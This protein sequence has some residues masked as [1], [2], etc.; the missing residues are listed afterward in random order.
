MTR[1]QLNLFVPHSE[2]GEPEFAALRRHV[3]ATDTVRPQTP[4]LTLAHPRNP[5]ALGNALAAARSAAAL[6]LRCD[7]LQWIE[8]V[9]QQSW[10]VVAVYPLG[11]R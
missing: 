8:H 11:N 9:D 5:K 7:R 1:R 10:S 4:H 3:L 6:T 2:S